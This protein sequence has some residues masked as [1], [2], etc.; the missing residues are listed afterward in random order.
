MS[1]GADG[2]LQ[3]NPCTPYDIGLGKLVDLETPEDFIGKEALRRIADEGTQRERSGF[4]IAGAPLTG[5]GHSIP[6]L[7]DKGQPR[8]VLS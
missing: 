8:G 2:R 6:V 7:D 5:A 4:V 3:T 1:Y